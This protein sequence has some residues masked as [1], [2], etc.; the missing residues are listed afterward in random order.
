MGVASPW[1]HET[2][3]DE[4]YRHLERANQLDS[5]GIMPAV[6]LVKLGY[7][8]DRPV[9]PALFGEII[10]RL[11]NYPLSPSDVTSIQDLADCLGGK[12]TMA[13]EPNPSRRTIASRFP[14]EYLA[15]RDRSPVVPASDRRRR[16]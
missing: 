4:A 10:N 15:R 6:T 2:S 7:L 3:I 1:D 9:D 5:T 16:S 13:Q 14:L 11:E 8:L 12:C